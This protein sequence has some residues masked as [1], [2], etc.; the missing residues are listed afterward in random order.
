MIGPGDRGL[1]GFRGDLDHGPGGRDVKLTTFSLPPRTTSWPARSP[2][3]QWPFF[4]PD[5]VSTLGR[6][7]SY[8]ANRYAAKIRGVPAADRAVTIGCRIKPGRPELIGAPRTAVTRP[9]VYRRSPQADPLMT[10]QMASGSGEPDHCREIRPR[11]HRPPWMTPERR[12]SLV[13]R[14]AVTVLGISCLDLVATISK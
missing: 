5:D 2:V 12:H 6:G 10:L 13:R 7:G 8:M 9:A 14:F 3:Y 4:R 1:V 11:A